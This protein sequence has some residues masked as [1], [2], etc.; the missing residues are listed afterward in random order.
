MRRCA[1]EFSISALGL[2]DV[3]AVNS[4]SP[5]QDAIAPALRTGVRGGSIMQG[6]DFEEAFPVFD[7]PIPHSDDEV[8]DHALA[9]PAWL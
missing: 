3:L 8:G 2:C 7:S 1:A 6:L 9:L 4:G 5:A